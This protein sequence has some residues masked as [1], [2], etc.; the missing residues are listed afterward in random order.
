MAELKAYDKADAVPPAEEVADLSQMVVTG[1]S[2]VV[3]R[4]PAE[5]EKP[6]AE[7]APRKQEKGA[8]K[9]DAAFYEQSRSKKGAQERNE[10]VTGV[11]AAEPARQKSALE[12]RNGNAPGSEA[13][14]R[15]AG[16]YYKAG[17]LKKAVETYERCLELYP[18]A[19]NAYI[20][21]IELARAY[22]E[23]GE[24]KRSHEILQK[25]L[26]LYPEMKAGIQRE[27]SKAAEPADHSGP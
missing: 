19:A 10:M 5:V 8:R 3:Y 18:N 14:F 24:K 20:V 21:T 6:L 1:E 15:E 23:L 25:A 22:R 16:T 2:P 11:T 27:I 4:K 17:N 9:G 12:L 26:I 13:L 7:V